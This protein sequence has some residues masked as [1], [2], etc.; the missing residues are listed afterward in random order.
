VYNR[1]REA[2]ANPDDP[3]II[4][5]VKPGKKPRGEGV[6]SRRSSSSSSSSA[7]PLDVSFSGWDLLIN[8]FQA[9]GVE[10]TDVRSLITASWRPEE[11]NRAILLAW[12]DLRRVLGCL[13]VRK[14]RTEDDSAP[15]NQDGLQEVA[16]EDP[17]ISQELGL[18]GYTEDP[19]I[20]EVE[21]TDPSG[22]VIESSYLLDHVIEPLTVEPEPLTSEPNSLEA[23][24]DIIN[25]VSPPADEFLDAAEQNLGAPIVFADD[26]VEPEP[27]P[28]VT[29][30]P[31]PVAARPVLARPQPVR[32]S[33]PPRPQPVPLGKPAAPS[34]LPE[35][36]GIFD[37]N[38]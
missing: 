5:N 10:V 29:P 21:E 17:V 36:G 26:P 34:R 24:S 20:L 35:W 15:V 38:V 30:I 23:W 13:P 6:E 16:G 14:Q 4:M 33:S 27:A 31:V 2:N 3:G 19:E 32:S 7:S 1:V 11:E 25:P 12:G 18:N 28:V 37:R 8:A 22:R 9:R